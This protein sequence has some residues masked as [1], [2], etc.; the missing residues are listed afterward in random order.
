MKKMITVI[1]CAISVSLAVQATCTY[2]LGGDAAWCTDNSQCSTY[3]DNLPQTCT[4]SG[5]LTGSEFDHQSNT[6]ETVNTMTGGSCSGSGFLGSFC[7]GGSVWSTDYNV[8][9][10]EQFCQDCGG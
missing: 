8:P 1:L 7:S 5:V 4:D 2:K 3:K 10:T 6:H 9:M